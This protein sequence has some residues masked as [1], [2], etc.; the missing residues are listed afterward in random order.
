MDR[1]SERK[2]H[3]ASDPP[4]LIARLFTFVTIGVVV[5]AFSAIPSG[6]TSPPS[7]V[8]AGTL[9]TNTA[10]HGFSQ[11]DQIDMLSPSL[12][13]ALATASRTSGSYR[14]YLVRTTNVA[15]T[16]TVV[17]ALPL[18]RGDYPAY[19]D[20]GAVD[21]DP[22]I[23]FVNSRIGYVADPNGPIFVT[24]NAGIT[25]RPVDVPGR[26]PSYGVSGST[27]SVVSERCATISGTSSTPRCSSAVSQYHVG[28]VT[29]FV[30]RR[31][32]GRTLRYSE[33]TA[34]LGV[35]PHMIQVVNKDN[36]GSS[37]SSSL[38]ITFSDGVRWRVMRNP[39]AK[40]MVEQLVVARDGEWLL[41]CFL[42][43]GMSQGTEK[44]FRS[45]NQGSS[46]S[47]LINDVR[48]TPIYYFFS[49]NDEA[50]YG[51]VMNP[52]GGLTFSPD[53]GATWSSVRAL[54]YSA[55]APESMS[56]FGPTLA[57]YQVFQG[58]M[59]VTDN[60]RTWRILP[61]LPA[62]VYRGMPI[63]T[64]AKVDVSMRHVTSGGLSYPYID[65]TNKGSSP[66]YLD[67]APNVQPIN[68]SG[69]DIGPPASTEADFNSGDFLVLAARGG[70]ANV[71]LF[72][73]PASSVRPRATCVAKE[74]SA[75][76]I[77]F[78]SPA[79]F[80]LLFGAH[81]ISTC[82]KLTN[83]NALNVRAGPGKP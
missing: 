78:G 38:L 65:F 25:W 40:L 12:G 50:L 14:Y 33:N 76:E 18:A 9:L 67:G 77:N 4:S 20:F 48:G 73:N 34:L 44:L 75:L 46:W 47:T 52:A 54:G 80:R 63:C 42:D 30:T 19:S 70:V 43:Q 62:G 35:A 81:P 60:G 26:S 83:L 17:G 16:W 2:S 24:V 37:A 13:Y 82:T 23:F 31:I 10:L 6:A 7:Y 36:D 64:H 3:R 79:V 58:P 57:I 21:S 39:C 29:P 66:C 28:S 41:S 22:H 68:A 74:A 15:K 5:T 32:P 56:M 27:M 61:P 72:I 71:P 11:V 8:R 55:G 53:G 51:V 45:M 49:G 59:F 1:H 69:R